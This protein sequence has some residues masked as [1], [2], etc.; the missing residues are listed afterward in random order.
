[1]DGRIFHI[2]EILS[3]N[4][5][6]AWCVDEMARIA[7][8][9]GSHFL[10]LFKKEIGMPP[11]AYL[12]SLRLERAKFL[13]ETTFLRIKEI[14]VQT[15]LVNDTQ[16]TRCFKKKFGITPSAYRKRCWEIEQ[17]IPPNRQ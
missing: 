5:G 14:G 15:G 17:S 13:I 3:Q 4:L 8:L 9:S 10:N 6:H 7:E 16:F 12:C 2:K 11:M 1:M